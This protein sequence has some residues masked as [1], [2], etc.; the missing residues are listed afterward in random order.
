MAAGHHGFGTKSACCTSMDSRPTSFWRARPAGRWL[1]AGLGLLLLAA[2]YKIGLTPTSASNGGIS[3]Q[4]AAASQDVAPP[5]S[6]VHR[7]PQRRPET[8]Q[9]ADDSTLEDGHATRSEG[10]RPTTPEASAALEPSIATTTAPATA[11]APTIVVPELPFPA[12]KKAAESG[13][14]GYLARTLAAVM[15]VLFIGGVAILIIKKV[16]PRLAVSPGS[17]GKRQVKV[18]ETTYIGPRKAL[19]L[20][21]VG[22]KKFLLSAAAE[23]VTLLADVTAALPV[24]FEQVHEQAIQSTDQAQSKQDGLQ[25]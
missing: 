16:L 8:H 4:L 1:L 18:L 2:V 6:A 21:Q 3:L 11:P 25:P 5:P 12:G 23:H 24:G 9:A 7:Q 14:E 19:H 13:E 15:V 22:Q 10:E 17:L 20:V